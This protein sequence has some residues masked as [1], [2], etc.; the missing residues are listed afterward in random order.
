MP[1]ATQAG[2]DVLQLEQ[3]DEATPLSAL[4]QAFVKCGV[5]DLV[6]KQVLAADPRAESPSSSSQLQVK[7]QVELELA[8]EPQ[9]EHRPEG[10]LEAAEASKPAVLRAVSVGDCISVGEW[11]LLSESVQNSLGQLLMPHQHLTVQ[12]R[13]LLTSWATTIRD[14]AG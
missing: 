1:F 4:L 7:L 3:M 6:V 5:P 13:D 12:T 11:L 2:S 14:N 9:A 10:Q 8:S